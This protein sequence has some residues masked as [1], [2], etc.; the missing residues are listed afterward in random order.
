MLWVHLLQ[1]EVPLRG[2]HFLKGKSKIAMTDRSR[3]ENISVFQ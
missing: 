2:A 3:M 1:M